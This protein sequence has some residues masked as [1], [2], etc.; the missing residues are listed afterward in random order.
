[1]KIKLSRNQ[2]FELAEVFANEIH[3]RVIEMH[4][5]TCDHVFHTPEAPWAVKEPRASFDEVCAAIRSLKPGSRERSDFVSTVG[6]YFKKIRKERG[7]FPKWQD[8]LARVREVNRDLVPTPFIYT[9]KEQA[10]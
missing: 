1:M 4:L 3:A 8:S 10:A 6:W 7:T 9:P 5:W 2:T